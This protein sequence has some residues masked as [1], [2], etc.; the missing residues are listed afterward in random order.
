MTS[1]SPSTIVLMR[2]E[3]TT[4]LNDAVGRSNERG[5]V[6][7]TYRDYWRGRADG[8]RGALKRLDEMEAQA[9]PQ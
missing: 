3:L 7:A 1:L 6:N 5:T 8:Y 4:A 2:E 9:K